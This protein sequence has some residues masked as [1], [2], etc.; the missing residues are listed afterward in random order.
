MM[1][2]KRLS[3]GACTLMRLPQGQTVSTNR[4]FREIG[5]FVPSRGFRICARRSSREARSGT[6]SPVIPR[7]ISGSPVGRWNWP[8]PDIHPHQ[9]GAGVE[10][11]I[12]RE[13]QCGDVIVRRQMLVGDA[14]VDV[15][16]IDDIAEILACAIVFLPS[17]G[18]FSSPGFLARRT[19]IKP[20]P[21]AALN[22]RAEQRHSRSLCSAPALA[23]YPL[24]HA[25]RR[26]PALQHG[27][28]RRTR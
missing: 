19:N 15:P 1:R 20:H 14:D 12:A 13:T 16:E 8:T 23:Q 26:A 28:P 17:H 22:G 2:P 9:A 6:T 10:K 11:R 5:N 7:S 4:C 24:S 3:S 21:C 27:S 18:G 25:S